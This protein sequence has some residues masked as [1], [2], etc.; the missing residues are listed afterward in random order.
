MIVFARDSSRGTPTSRLKNWTVASVVDNCRARAQEW[1]AAWRKRAESVHKPPQLGETM[2]EFP[3]A[4]GC[5]W[6][7]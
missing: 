4:Y 2:G 3:P 7:L 5:A 6:H 1:A